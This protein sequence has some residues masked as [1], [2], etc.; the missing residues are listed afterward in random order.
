[1]LFLYN[2]VRILRTFTHQTNTY[3]Y[4]DQRAQAVSAQWECNFLRM[5]H[6]DLCEAD[7]RG[8]S[9]LSPTD[10]WLWDRLCWVLRSDS[11]DLPSAVGSWSGVKCRS[12]WCICVCVYHVTFK[13][14]QG[15]MIVFTTWHYLHLFFLP[16]TVKWSKLYKFYYIFF[17]INT[18]LLMQTG[19]IY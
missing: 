18:K 12:K 9:N 17:K 8:R 3:V 10:S 14:L 7:G 11:K 5:C 1:M 16:K 15:Y 6:W 4:T 13:V 19:L 2:V